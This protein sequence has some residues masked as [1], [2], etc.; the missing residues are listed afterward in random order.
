MI[1]ST[2]DVAVR[3]A[4]VRAA[5]GIRFTATGAD[6]EELIPK[7]LEYVA[8]RCDD[9]LWPAASREVRR[10]IADHR[11]ADAIAFYF[12]NVGSRWDEEWLEIDAAG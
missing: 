5:D 4:V 8:G 9:T 7:L 2:S 11:D 3:T 6:D 10:L 1:E 12:R